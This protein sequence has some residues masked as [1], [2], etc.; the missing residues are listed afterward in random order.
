M[1]NGVD[2]GIYT[3]KFFESGI[4]ERR[5]W[6]GFGGGQAWGNASPQASLPFAARDEPKKPT[7]TKR[8]SLH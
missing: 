5:T 8:S 3:G 1:E 2:I 6:R 7:L 4:Q